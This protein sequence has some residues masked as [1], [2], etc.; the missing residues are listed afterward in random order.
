M[1][2][3]TPI[4]IIMTR[5]LELMVN[6]IFRD[7]VKLLFG[8]DCYVNIDSIRYSTNTKTFIVHSKVLIK[9]IND[10]NTN[11]YREKLVYLI[12]EGWRYLGKDSPITVVTS[13]DII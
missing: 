6:L 3:F 1:S 4:F 2:N 13:I 12:S 11:N 9:E 8:E 5:G 10:E 7:D